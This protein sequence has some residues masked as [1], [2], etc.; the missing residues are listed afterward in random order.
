MLQSTPLICGR[1]TFERGRNALP[2]IESKEGD[3]GSKF[4]GGIAFL[5]LWVRAAATG[6]L[7]LVNSPSAHVFCFDVRQPSDMVVIEHRRHRIH[8]NPRIL[9]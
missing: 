3:R 8:G 4:F 1:M 7:C 9:P 2:P 5:G 6:I